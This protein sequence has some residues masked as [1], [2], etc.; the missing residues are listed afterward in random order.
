MEPFVNRERSFIRRLQ[1]IEIKIFIESLNIPRSEPVIL[2]GDFNM[3]YIK[4]PSEILTLMKYN[5][6]ELPN[7]KGSQIFSSDASNYLVGKD[8]V[9]EDNSCNQ[10]YLRNLTG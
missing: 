8:G 9:A 3:D 4:Y 7:F 6:L 2:L 1:S 10:Q 5:N